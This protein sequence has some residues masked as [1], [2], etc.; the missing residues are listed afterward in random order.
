MRVSVGIK[1]GRVVHSEH[2]LALPTLSQCASALHHLAS[3]DI[4]L[5]LYSC[6]LELPATLYLHLNTFDLHS[7]INMRGIFTTLAVLLSVAATV[8]SHGVLT[9]VSGANG[10]NAIGFAVV[11]GT[12]RDTGRGVKKVEV[13]L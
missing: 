13:C 1:A 5:S 7:L 3:R 11:E 10:V 2:P 4:F 6:C 9:G 12:P 8:R